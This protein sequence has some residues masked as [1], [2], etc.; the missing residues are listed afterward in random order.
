MF[1]WQPEIHR[2]ID[3]GEQLG[4]WVMS[5]FQETDRDS[6]FHAKRICSRKV[7]H[8]DKTFCHQNEIVKRK[9][10]VHIWTLT[11]LQS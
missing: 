10:S 4:A 11:A 9:Q 6:A 7:N 5:K 1:P 2:G 8:V 3:M